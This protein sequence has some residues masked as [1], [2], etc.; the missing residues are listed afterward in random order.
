MNA[1]T[2]EVSFCAGHRLC[3]D[4]RGKCNNLHGHNYKVNATIAG[5]LNQNGMVVDFGQLKRMLKAWIDTNWDHGFLFYKYDPVV[6]LLHNFL[7]PED[8]VQKCYFFDDNPT[9]E[10]M[11]RYLHTEVLPEIIRSLGGPQESVYVVGV[12]VEETPG[13]LAL[14]RY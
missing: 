8:I 9:A 6:E 3:K 11:A 4:Y 13:C 7:L 1:I 14:S 10:V 5:R 2:V 12:S